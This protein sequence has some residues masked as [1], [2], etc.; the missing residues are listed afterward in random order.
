MPKESKG[1]KSKGKRE[2]KGKEDHVAKTKKRL[3][4]DKTVKKV[5]LEKQKEAQKELSIDSESPK[6]VYAKAK[7]IGMSARKARLVV[8]LVRGKRA[9]DAILELKFLRK[10]AALPIRKTIESAIANAENNFEMDKKSL[11]VKE[12]FI[13]EAPTFKRGR[14]GSRG[15]YKKILKRNCHIT[16]GVMEGT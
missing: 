8:D 6:V 16:I 13:D 4:S 2:V 3:V 12:A 1:K 9:L 15:R 5:G 7:Y 14:A 10:K 11:I